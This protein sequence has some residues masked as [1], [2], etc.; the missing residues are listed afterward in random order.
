M[1]LQLQRGRGIGELGA[2]ELKETWPI[3]NPLDMGEGDRIQTDVSRH[4]AH[5]STR[6]SLALPT[7]TT[8]P[9]VHPGRDATAIGLSAI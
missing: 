8:R 7:P 4:S 6:T 9:L 2:S 3:L 5:A 1:Q